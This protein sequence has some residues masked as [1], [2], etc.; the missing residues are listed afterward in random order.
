MAQ[1]DFRKPST[2]VLLTRKER[3]LQD[4]VTLKHW[5]RVSGVCLCLGMPQPQEGFAGRLGMRRSHEAVGKRAS[6][7]HCCSCVDFLRCSRARTAIAPCPPQ[8]EIN[9]RGVQLISCCVLRQQ[10]SSSC[11]ITG[12]T[13]WCHLF[14]THRIYRSSCRQREALKEL[15]MFHLRA[16]AVSLLNLYGG[17]WLIAWNDRGT[18]P[19]QDGNLAASFAS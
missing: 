7:L 8:A 6:L 18:P 1:G 15:V 14:R 16:A 4:R 12:T 2:S 9:R 10:Q 13:P 19:Y 11:W 5:Q 17:S 3:S